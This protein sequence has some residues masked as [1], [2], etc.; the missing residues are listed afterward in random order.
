MTCPI[1]KMKVSIKHLGTGKHV[2]ALKLMLVFNLTHLFLQITNL[3]LIR[4]LQKKII[5]SFVAILLL[6]IGFGRVVEGG[7][8]GGE[9]RTDEVKIKL[10]SL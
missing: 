10:Q 3:E 4:C 1:D 2:S 6:Y 7:G 9:V 8:G 5:F